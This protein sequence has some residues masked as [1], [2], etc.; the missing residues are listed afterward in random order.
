[1]PVVS[2]IMPVYNVK[3]F[4]G[5]AVASVLDQTYRDFELIVVDDGSTDGSLSVV[6]SIVRNFRDPR[7]RLTSQPN[8]GLAGARNT[9]IRGARGR[10]V[11]FL[12]SDDLWEPEKLAAHVRHLESSPDVGVSYSP[13]EF[14]DDAGRRLGYYQMPKLTGVDASHILLRNP[15][16][17][18]SAPVIRRETL[19]AIRFTDSRN[20]VPEQCYFDESFR[21]SEDIECWVRIATTTPWRFEGLAR[22]L[23]LYRVNATGLSAQLEKQFASW[24]RM[25]AKAQAFAPQFTARWG[26][27]ARACQLR[28]LARRAVRLGLGRRAVQY[29]HRAL[30][31]D[32]RIVALEP[33]R[34]VAT[35]AAAYLQWLLPRF[36]YT[37]A[38]SVMMRLAGLRQ[39]LGTAGAAGSK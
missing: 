24:E 37:R 13:S 22:P 39:R 17:N 26:S 4:V 30:T 29:A 5:A 16:G 9:G 35:L 12:D 14:I 10:Y 7:V 15:V 38:E 23:T 25:L 2:V 36:V 34:T 32:L 19:Q 28:Y 1:M 3:P 33:A 31:C 6:L 27:L 21:Q 11:A 20:G 18:G 8:R